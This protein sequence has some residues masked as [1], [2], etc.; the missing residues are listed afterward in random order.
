MT[1]RNTAGNR[2]IEIRRGVIG[3]V[4]PRSVAIN[5]RKPE[6]YPDLP[7]AYL[8]VAEMWGTRFGGPPLC[9]EYV[10]VLQHVFTEEEARAVR[11]L[12]GARAGKTAAEIAEAEHRSEEEISR[13]MD[14]LVDEKHVILASDREEKRR[15][16]LQPILPGAWESIL[17]R[18]SL[19]SLTDWHIKFVELFLPLYQTGFTTIHRGRRPPGIR[20]LP[21]G[22]SV[23]YS[24]TAALP[25]DKLGEIFDHY[26]DFAV[27][28]CQCRMGAGIIGQSCGRP[29]ENC[30]TMGRLATSLV[31]SGQMRRINIKEAL[32]IKAEAEASGLVS[33][34][35]NFEIG[36]SNTSCSCCGCCCM[37]MRTISE[38][39][40]PGYIAPPH[41]M[42]EVDSNKCSYCGKCA[43]SCPMGAW[44][45][46]TKRKTRSFNSI[47]CIGC[48]LCYVACDKEK[49]I[50]LKPV[51]GYKPPTVIRVERASHPL[52]GISGIEKDEQ[53][54]SDS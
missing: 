16:L 43:R 3:P 4:E 36:K 46:D 44:T 22:Q 42:P 53:P 19:D 6:D 29:M 17:V 54:K 12:R 24:P 33:W 18:T 49:A 9:D 35:S 37:M 13:I 45:V 28:L 34:T 2:L 51:P 23:E 5:E 10:E 48:G 14:V 26:N 32:E 41:F 39:N 15:Y 27:G 20:Y 11:H 25:S 50:E 8:D 52:A 47:R 38:F 1:N 30:I 7:Q 40:A 31:K 21:V